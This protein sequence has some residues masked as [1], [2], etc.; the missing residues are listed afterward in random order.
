MNVSCHW[1]PLPTAAL[2]FVA[3]WAWAAAAVGDETPA[4]PVADP[5]RLAALVAQLGSED[6][7][8]REAASEALMRVGLPAFG[9]LE[10]ATEHPDREV[11]YRS[12]RILAQIRELDLQRRLDA[13]LSGK[14]EPDE[15]PLPGWSRF[16][17]A[18][19]DTSHSRQLFVDLQ[20]ADPELMQAL[21]RE[22][23]SAAE[24]LGQRTQQHQD[25]LRFGGGQQQL[26]LG[27]IM[28]MAFV[29]AQEDL[30]PADHTL[31]MVLGY[32]QQ[33]PYRE[34]MNNPTKREIPRKMV[35]ALIRRSE[36]NSAYQAMMLAITYSLDDGLVPA[37]RI[38]KQ[39]AR[40]PHMSLYALM[41]VAKLGDR[42]H[43][44]LVEKLLD[45]KSVVTRTQQNKVIHEIQIRDAALA[46]GVLLTKQDL[47]AYYPDRGE[48]PT[49]D[50]QQV[51]F[52][53][54]LIGFSPEPTP[55]DGQEQKEDP[56]AAVLKKWQEF[57]ARQPRTEPKAD[58]DSKTEA[59]PA[60]SPADSK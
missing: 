53:P 10:A 19:G 11:R 54:K 57:K 5:A 34:A 59:A 24:L 4:K 17:K 12:V 30:T 7:S 32:C 42:S 46:A 23:K 43:L 28:T 3:A 49:S 51:F 36:D 25:A 1:R 31:S 22:P 27:Q 60:A 45:D 37:V 26:T 13:F 44:P 14:E 50:P 16:E 15:Y 29:A 56:R 8:E 6:F 21:E 47:K 18:Y 9:A 2:L 38:L 39:G 55:G 20:R 35:G 40:V 48:F 33:S 52:N 41:T 58:E